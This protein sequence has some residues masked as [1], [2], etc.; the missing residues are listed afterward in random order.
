[1]LVHCQLPGYTYTVHE[2][3]LYFFSSFLNSWPDFQ[4]ITGRRGRPSHRSNDLRRLCRNDV[5]GLYGRPMVEIHVQWTL[6]ISAL[7]LSTFSYTEYRRQLACPNRWNSN[8]WWL[9][10]RSTIPIPTVIEVVPTVS[11]NPTVYVLHSFRALLM[12]RNVDSYKLKRPKFGPFLEETKIQPVILPPD[13]C[14]VLIS[15][16]ALPLAFVLGPTTGS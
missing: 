7:S 1:M 6:D 13:R 10:T 5:S 14:L 9:L 8:G 2:V 16:E 3:L 11:I 12:S 4:L 15:T